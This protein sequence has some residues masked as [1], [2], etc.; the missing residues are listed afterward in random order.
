VR[1]ARLAEQIAEANATSARAN[2]LPQVFVRG[3]FEADRERFVTRGASNWLFEAGLRWTVFHGGIDKA[4]M[5]EAGHAYRAATADARR[6]QSAIGLEIREA[7]SNLAAAGERIAAAEA[8]AGEA[9]ESLRIIKNRFEAG[10]STVTDLLRA[11]T[12]LLDARTRRIAAIH[13]QRMAAV[14]VQ[15]AAGTLTENSEVLK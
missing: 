13:D 8:A 12:A 14:N 15:L 10:L 4:R 3:V 1:Q 9:E 6:A 5:T 7:V 11:E 2:M